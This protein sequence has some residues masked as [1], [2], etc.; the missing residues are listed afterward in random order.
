MDSLRFT[1]TTNHKSK[2]IINDNY[3]KLCL[4]MNLDDKME[5]ITQVEKNKVSFNESKLD[6]RKWDAIIGVISLRS[7]PCL[8]GVSS[9]KLVATMFKQEYK[10]KDIYV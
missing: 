4:S 2:L 8:I 3:S 9:R 6:E 1:C 7:G 5:L 10:S